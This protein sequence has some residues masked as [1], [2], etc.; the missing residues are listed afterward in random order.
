MPWGNKI[1]TYKLK[2]IIVKMTKLNKIHVQILNISINTVY[3]YFSKIA[4]N[5]II[6]D[7]IIHS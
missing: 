1:Y 4:I 2:E 5:S 3:K 6:T 7:C